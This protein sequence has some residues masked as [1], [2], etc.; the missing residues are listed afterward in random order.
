MFFVH[1]A[2]E[3]PQTLDTSRNCSPWTKWHK[4]H[5]HHQ[6]PRRSSRSRPTCLSPWKLHRT[7]QAN[8][9]HVAYLRTHV[10]KVVTID[11]YYREAVVGQ[12]LKA[13]LKC[14]KNRQI[15]FRWRKGGCCYNRRPTRDH[16]SAVAKNVAEC[17]ETPWKIS[18]TKA[19]LAAK[20]V[21]I[22]IK[23]GTKIAKLGNMSSNVAAAPFAILVH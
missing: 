12:G 4:Q 7:P 16:N 6:H 3:L 21:N 10:N 22:S 19:P 14:F 9:G 13:P 18:A 11:L 23:R 5:H 2:K 1:V 17:P 8:L 20:S 15:T